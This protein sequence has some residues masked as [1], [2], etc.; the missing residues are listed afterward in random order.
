MYRGFFQPFALIA[1]LLVPCDLA[2]EGNPWA[3]SPVGTCGGLTS[4]GGPGPDAP[5]SLFPVAGPIPAGR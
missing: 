5:L 1:A 2:A 4:S 3:A